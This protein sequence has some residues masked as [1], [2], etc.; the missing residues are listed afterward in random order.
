MKECLSKHALLLLKSRN[1]A[2]R[3]LI[4]IKSKDFIEWKILK[5]FTLLVIPV[6]YTGWYMHTNVE[7]KV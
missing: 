2:D 1:E 7:Q 5:A 4:N 6:N 3:K